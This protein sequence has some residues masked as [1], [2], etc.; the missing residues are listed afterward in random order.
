METDEL[1]IWHLISQDCFVA[2]EQQEIDKIFKVL[3]SSF[4][5]PVSKNISFDLFVLYG[6]Y[7][8]MA[9]NITFWYHQVHYH[10]TMAS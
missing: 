3:S 5:N 9:K 2:L 4:I 1:L 6:R 10:T 7:I 8:S